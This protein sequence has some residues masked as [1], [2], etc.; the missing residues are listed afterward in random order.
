MN[1]VCIFTFGTVK[2]YWRE[3]MHASFDQI[4]EVICLLYINFIN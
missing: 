2:L 3:I 1:N 4:A